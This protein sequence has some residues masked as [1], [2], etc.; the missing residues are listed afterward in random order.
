MRP[1][2]DPELR[3]QGHDVNQFLAREIQTPSQSSFSLITE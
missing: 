3:M 1:T 2:I